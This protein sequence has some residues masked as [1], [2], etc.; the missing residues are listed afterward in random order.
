M[1]I[2]QHWNLPGLIGRK[3]G[4]VLRYLTES[5]EK[6]VR[7]GIGCAYIQFLDIEEL[8]G[9]DKL[10]GTGDMNAQRSSG[11]LQFTAEAHHQRE[12]SLKLRTCI[13]R[14]SPQQVVQGLSDFCQRAGEL[15]FLLRR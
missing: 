15:L 14:A 3:I 8:P 10:A 5:P 1:S 11:I 13:S 2:G 6:P 9:N 4:N 7:N 12:H